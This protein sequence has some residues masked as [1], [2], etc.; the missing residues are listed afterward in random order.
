MATKIENETEFLEKVKPLGIGPD[1]IMNFR[2]WNWIVFDGREA[3]LEFLF[4][5]ADEGFESEDVET[6]G[7]FDKSPEICVRF[8]F[9]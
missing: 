6:R 8:R 4:F 9:R 3:S 2:G 5:L 7:V 1:D